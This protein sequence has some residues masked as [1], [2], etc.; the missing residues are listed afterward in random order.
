MIN[1]GQ[2]TNGY[3][4]VPL[5]T[6]GIFVPIIAISGLG[7][8]RLRI[9]L[10]WLGLASV[11]SAALGFYDSN[12]MLVGAAGFV[13][14]P[15]AAILFIL[16]TLVV[17]GETDRRWIATYPTHFNVAWKHAVQIILAELFVGVFWVILALGAA[18]FS[19]VKVTFFETLIINPKFAIPVT[20]VGLACALQL[21]DVRTELVQGTRTL[22]LMLLSW[23]LPVMAVLAVGFLLALPFTG[24][25]PLWNTNFGA[26]LLL[27]T[28]AA[29]ILL[30]NTVYQDG[31]S[32]ANAIL[33]Y[34]GVLVPVALVPL[35]ALAG[36]ALMLRVEQYGWTSDRVL[37]FACIFVAACYAI[38]Y[39]YAVVRS[40]PGLQQIEPVNLITGGV[41]IPGILIVL[42]TPIADPI[43]ISVA[44]QIARL[45]S[46]QVAPDK[47]DY[48][49]L[50]FGSGRYGH[51]ALVA[52]T[53]KQDG[54]GASVIAARAKQAI[55]GETSTVAVHRDNLPTVADRLNNITV[56]YPDG[57]K[58]P[59]SLLEQDWTTVS[60]SSLPECIFGNVKCEALLIDIDGDGE[61]E[62]L[63]FGSTALFA[64]VFKM[65]NGKWWTYLGL[66][67]GGCMRVHDALQT[68][69]IETVAPLY[70][71]IQIGGLRLRVNSEFKCPPMPAVPSNAA[72]SRRE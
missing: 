5:L 4:F 60:R 54:Q 45:E 53:K 65:Q 34:S 46:E 50:R 19:L 67:T 11:L 13:I 15:L 33:R 58:F 16:H 22:L 42:N 55:D 35:A 44:S 43:R 62:V 25:E 28:S 72:D 66:S 61:D 69:R 39:S 10:I 64:S 41:V 3:I 49:F 18:L 71:D 9:L 12:R 7:N 24:L 27:A 8:L 23:L 1:F 57:A 48:K 6:V 38:G 29:L 21:T 31:R 59:S 47:F 70:K 17:S 2:G 20:T 32:N 36:Y 51:E 52:L 40:G 63:L 14:V 56:V 30:V 37:V 26:S 68:G